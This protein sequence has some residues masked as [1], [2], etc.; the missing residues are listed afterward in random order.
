MQHALVTMLAMPELGPDLDQVKHR[1]RPGPARHG[2]RLPELVP[3]LDQVERQHC[4]LSAGH[5]RCVCWESETLRWRL[6]AWTRTSTPSVQLRVPLAPGSST[7][8]STR[9]H[10]P[11]RRCSSEIRTNSPDEIRRNNSVAQMRGS[12]GTAEKKERFKSRR[13]LVWPHA[14]DTRQ[15][16]FSRASVG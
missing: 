4:Q 15:R 8:C 3:N 16:P 13:G 7:R 5:G 6:T 12:D 1:Q 14:P 11:A 9:P 2:Q 10:N